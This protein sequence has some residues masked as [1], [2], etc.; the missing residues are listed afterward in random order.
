MSTVTLSKETFAILESFSTINSSIVFKKGN[1]IRTFSNAE[2][3]LGEYEAEEFFPQ[4]FAI[5]DLSQFLSAIRT[6]RSDTGQLPNLE[7]LN[8]DYVVI[9]SKGANVRYYYSDPE[10]TLKT[11]PEK[12]VVFPGANIEF[13]CSQDMLKK[14]FELSNTLQLRDLIFASKDDKTFVKLSDRENDTANACKFDVTNGECTGDYNFPM[15]IDN[16][17]IYTKGADYKVRV[18]EGITE[19]VV[20]KLWNNEDIQ[21]KYYVA[22]EPK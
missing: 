5:Y 22:L 21:L 8:E 17:L 19:W 2:N 6:L 4:D 13:D 11:A 1:R 12:N 20:T 15:K 7:F 18:G 10:I 14:I 16:L 9:R 3:V